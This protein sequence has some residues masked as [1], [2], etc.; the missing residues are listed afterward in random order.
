MMPYG[1]TEP[2]QLRKWINSTWILHLMCDRVI[3]L[4]WVRWHLKSPASWLFTTIYSGTFERKYQSST[5]MVFVRGIH[6]WPVNSP[7]KGPV[8]RKMFRFDDVIMLS[9]Q[10]MT[11]MFSSWQKAF[12]PANI[13]HSWLHAM[14]WIL[15]NYSTFQRRCGINFTLWQTFLILIQ[16][17]T[18]CKISN[19]S[20][21]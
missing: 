5:S 16:T 14:S 13:H 8:T 4:R 20:C 21:T 1:V 15:T 12:L 19:I 2:H 17:F 3:P 9:L 6:W 7:L 11:A 10:Q 18:Y